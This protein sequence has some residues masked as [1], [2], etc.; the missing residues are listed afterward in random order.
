MKLLPTYF[1]QK[2]RQGLSKALKGT[3]NHYSCILPRDIGGVS[4][5]I[6]KLFYSG[7]KIDEKQTTA[8]RELEKDAIVVYVSKFTNYFEFLFYYRRYRQLDLPF[9]QIGFDY[10]IFFWQPLSQVCSLAL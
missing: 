5:I 6:L 2:L 3:H 7:I 4:A 9:P 8:I 10:K 1:S